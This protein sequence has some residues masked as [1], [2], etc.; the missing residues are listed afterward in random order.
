MQYFSTDSDSDFEIDI[1]IDIDRNENIG[2]IILESLLYSSI[3]SITDLNL[4]GNKSWF[5]HLDT[6]QERERSGSAE[7]LAEFISNQAGIQHINL[8]R[9]Y[10]SSSATYTIVTKIAEHPSTSSKL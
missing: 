2:E 4:S 5:N 9:N 8:D 6:Q 10:F 7:L 1:D 3:N